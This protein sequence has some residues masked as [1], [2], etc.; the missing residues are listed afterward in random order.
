MMH[1]INTTM[2][3]LKTLLL[4]GFC[5]QLLLGC[6]DAETATSPTTTPNIEEDA[7]VSDTNEP[8]NQ[9]EDSS[10]SDEED[11]ETPPINDVEEEDTT[12]S[13]EVVE[14]DTE[15]PEEEDAE[16]DPEDT[17][18]PSDIIDEPDVVI[19]G[20]CETPKTST[21]QIPL[22]ETLVL[23]GDDYLSFWDMNED[24]PVTL[25]SA[26]EGALAQV[27]DGERWTPDVVGDWVFLRGA[28][29]AI[30]QVRDDLLNEDTFINYNYTPASPLLLAGED[31]LYVTATT[32]NGV[33]K[34]TLSP[35]G[36]EETTFIPTGS[37]PTG[38]ALTDE[39]ETLLVTQTG[40]DSLGF[41]DVSEGR[42]TDS[43][44]IGDEPTGIVVDG[45]TAWV[46][47]S[48]ANQVAQIDLTARAVVKVIPVGREPR[49]MAYDPV[50]KR[51]YIAALISSNT[52]PQGPLQ[53]EG[54]APDMT[55]RDIS[56][57]DTENAVLEATIPHV[58][59]ILRGVWLTEDG[60]TLVV[61]VSHSLNQLL[62]VD[63][64]SR[65]HTHGLA[66]VDVSEGSE[67]PVTHLDLDEQPTSA[68]PAPSPFTMKK[69]PEGDELL[70]T[71]SAGARILSLNPENYEEL[72][73]VF[74]GNDPRG[75]VTAHGRAWT[76][77]WLDD[78]V[79]GV[80][81]PLW[82]AEAD[83]VVSTAIGQDPTP[84]NIR[85]GQRIFND[86]DF[87]KF[88]AFS[89]NN[90]H[91]DGLTDGLVWDIL[92]D[93]PVNTP[94]FR[95]I[96]G[97][98]PFLWGGFLPTLFDFSREVL[99]LVGADATGEEME[100]L[101]LYMQS[102]TAPP[103]P[104]ALPGGKLSPQ[105]LLG[106]EVFENQAKCVNCHSGPLFTNQETVAGKTPG[107]DTDVPALIGVYDT[108]P[109]GREGQWATLED[110]V[111]FA[112]EF[113]ESTLTP[114][115]L[116]A[117]NAYVREVPGEA[118]YLNSATPLNGDQHV[119]FETQVQLMFS[120]VLVEGQEDH[121]ILE[122]LKTSETE[123]IEAEVVE[124]EW[125][126]SG[127]VARFTP[128]QDLDLETQYRIRVLPEMKSVLGQTLF[129]ELTI[130]FRTGGIPE[131][132]VSG[133]WDG[134]L[135]IEDP[136]Q[137]VISGEFAFL[138]SSGGKVSG[139]ILVE[140]DEITLSHFE[141]VVSG[142]TLVL[143][144]FLLETVIGPVMVENGEAVLSDLDGDGFA[145]YG[146]GYLFALGYPIDFTFS[147]IKMPDG[148]PF[149]AP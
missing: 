17:E 29:E 108:A 133:T 94:A 112:A 138:Q 91:V 37:W 121:F 55:V 119:F 84:D 120:Q 86:G 134:T 18:E 96:G 48:G 141:A 110:M 115:E 139:V 26:P 102:V 40:R 82:E 52:H 131:T 23:L 89:C 35:D 101:T 32:S 58:G 125:N 132:D 70:I 95:N 41:I 109:Y 10:G 19:Y 107:L 65:P 104:Y 143:E 54:V 117:L 79:A 2:T 42:L 144:P 137:A 97:T 59:T 5:F 72:G 28:H 61:G 90:C 34:V 67:Y 81:L 147:R 80:P 62:A 69:S 46:A 1:R 105:G 130:F 50:R 6:G 66:F 39:G 114:E 47:L 24:C 126:V 71:L 148:T 43:I 27:I 56:I 25:E 9:E 57:I 64:D 45:T 87:S 106:K 73:R 145:D 111:E 122:T 76:Y 8:S 83:D 135:A 53:E 116:A 136:I 22:G 98:G 100:L 30:L 15:E 118:L 16:E 14:D 140:V 77:S 13:P 74:V 31:T 3:W 149:Q 4:I 60:N 12:E 11:A 63:A 49:A 124:G 38:L 127:R 99:K 85:A 78:V 129:E 7:S 51:L 146:E 20:P 103:N 123:E 88:G 36:A 44:R 93:G 68:G 21:V 92:V 33:S 142:D 128:A 113:T 75:L